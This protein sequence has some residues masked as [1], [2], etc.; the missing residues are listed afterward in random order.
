MS[1]KNQRFAK[2]GGFVLTWTKMA[3]IH[4]AHGNGPALIGLA[5]VT[6]SPGETNGKPAEND[7]NQTQEPRNVYWQ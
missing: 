2:P 3:T 4:A 6:P 5:P 1:Q 7:P